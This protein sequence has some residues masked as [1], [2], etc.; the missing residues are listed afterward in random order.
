MNRPPPPSYQPDDFRPPL[1]SLALAALLGYA[2]YWLYSGTLRTWEWAPLGNER[3]T[4]KRLTATPACRWPRSGA[5]SPASRRATRCGT[6]AAA[7]R[8]PTTS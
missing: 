2:A 3:R 1:L 4:G 6:G 7:R 8:R 5:G